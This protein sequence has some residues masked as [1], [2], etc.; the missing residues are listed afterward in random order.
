MA[1]KYIIK[2][3]IPVPTRQV[4]GTLADVL[5]KTEIGDCV[6]LP[7]TSNVYAYAKRTGKK[8]CCRR[9]K[10]GDTEFFRLWVVGVRDSGNAGP[11]SN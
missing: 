8:V 5:R 10:D 6:D 2:K 1:D 7:I 3:G 4:R 9:M 11:N